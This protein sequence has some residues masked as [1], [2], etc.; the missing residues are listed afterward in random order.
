MIAVLYA[1]PAG[2]YAGLPDVDLWDEAR[3]ARRYAGP[4]PVVAHPP[5]QRWCKMAP[6]NQARYGQPVGED[7][8]C[9]AAALKAVQRFGGVLEHPAHSYAWAAHGLPWPPESGGWQRDIAGGWCCYVEQGHYGH[10]A[11][12][13]TWLYAVNTELPE[14]RWGAYD[15]PTAWISA[16]RPRAILNAMGIAQLSKRQASATPPRFRDVLLAL[17]VSARVAA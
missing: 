17:A 16:D 15:G 2:V 7:D 1:D 12:K 5:C 6:V 8:G 9:F 4:W 14:L 10:A 3:D 11:R 13:P